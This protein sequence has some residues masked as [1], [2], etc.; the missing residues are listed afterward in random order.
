MLPA[1]SSRP[2]SRRRLKVTASLALAAAAALVA[3]LLTTAPAAA[4]GPAQRDSAVGLRTRHD[5]GPPRHYRMVPGH[6]A[7]PV[8]RAGGT[9]A[10]D[11]A[12]PATPPA[13]PQAGSATV[14]VPAGTRRAGRTSGTGGTA[15]APQPAGPGAWAPADRLPV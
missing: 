12:R 6:H 3:P 2:G 10:A 11:I 14:A 13:W 15:P 5:L 7:G 4:G 1:P 9:P 8:R